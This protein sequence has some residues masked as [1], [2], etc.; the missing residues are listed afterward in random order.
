ML[1]A[2]FHTHT[3]YCDGKS[4]PRGDGGSGVQKGL[5]DFGV[6]GHADFSF[7][8]ENF[9]MTDQALKQY[10]EELYR[11]REEYAGR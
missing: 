8:L 10:K 4:T 1:R 7:C 11:L 9:G 3:T 5:T 6:S 2:D